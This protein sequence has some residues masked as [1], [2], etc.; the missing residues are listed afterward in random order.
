MS[1]DTTPER[2]LEERLHKRAEQM[3]PDR[4]VPTIVRIIEVRGFIASQRRRGHSWDSLQRMLAKEHVNLAE[5]TLRN[6][7]AQ[8]L[9][10]EADLKAAGKDI[11]EDAEIHAAIRT[12]VRAPHQT[13]LPA[14]PDQSIAPVSP[15]QPPKRQASVL[16]PT[17]MTTPDPYQD[18]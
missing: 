15:A 7:M 12:Q 13:R 9:R 6:Y 11:P 8:I 17:T 3:A 18:L 16:F 1:N 14:Q 5:G 2:P 4:A 10:A